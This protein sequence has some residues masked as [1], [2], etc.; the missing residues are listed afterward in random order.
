M[1]VL[2]RQ[3]ISGVKAVLILDDAHLRN[4]TLND[5]TLMREIVCMLVSNTT[6]QIEEIRLAV[7]RE[8]ATSCR[9][10]AHNLAGV[11][12][13]LGAMSM[14]ALCRILER[15][16]AAG[17]TGKCRSSLDLLNTELEYLRQAA[18]VFN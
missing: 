14:A 12:G 13:N 16:A 17:D 3:E 4:V 11:C 7:E 15:D 2:R 10:V 8:D 1:K 5:E 6:E 9:R 18:S